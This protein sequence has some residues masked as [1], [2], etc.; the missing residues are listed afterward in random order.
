ML[1]L[2][3]RWWRAETLRGRLAGYEEKAVVVAWR[4]VAREFRKNLEASSSFL[5]SPWTCSAPREGSGGGGGGVGKPGRDVRVW[6]P[7]LW[8]GPRQRLAS[9]T[10]SGFS[11]S[12]C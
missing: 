11:I 4:G 7:L 2:E 6:R 12:L 10:P 3:W 5:P 8:W 1:G 9:L